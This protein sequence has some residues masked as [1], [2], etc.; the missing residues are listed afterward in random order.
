[1]ACFAKCHMLTPARAK[2][3]TSL[4]FPLFLTHL[5]LKPQQWHWLS[6][7]ICLISVK[8][9]QK[10]KTMLLLPN[11]N[12]M[13][14]H[15]TP[16]SVHNMTLAF[17]FPPKPSPVCPTLNTLWGHIY[18][19]LCVSVACKSYTPKATEV[20]KCMRDMKAFNNLTFTFK[21]FKVLL[22]CFQ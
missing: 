8:L 16:T 2:Q 1:M 20:N 19:Y 7:F 17:P 3:C 11:V 18:N 13:T 15:A 4:Q 12:V 14:L 6:L 21:R 22:P 9:Y 10:S 5:G